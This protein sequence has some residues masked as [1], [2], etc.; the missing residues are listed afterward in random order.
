MVIPMV[1]LRVSQKQYLERTR[2]VV[3]ELREK[4]QVLKK[5][6]EEILELNDGLLVTLSEI[7][8]LRDPY[9]LGHSKLVSQYATDIAR[10]LGLKE[11]Q[12][13]L[14]RKAGLLHDIGKLGIPM[15]ILTK[16]GRLTHQEY[17]T[18]KTHSVLGGDLVKNSPSLRP[19][20]SI[21]RHHHEHFN[22]EGYP[23]QIAGSQ[24]SI[25]AR[26]VAVADAIEAMTS[27]RPY[28]KGL[29]VEQVVEELN[30]HSGTQFD[31]LVVSAAVRMLNEMEG[32][33]AQL[34]EAP[35]GQ[36]LS[37]TKLRPA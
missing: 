32:S 10:L 25:E 4:N 36:A 9:V 6:S 12:M 17:E 21:I 18:V 11:K 3:T 22:G 8:D 26:I 2:A 13:D 19:L 24:I 5:N 34:S 23:D 1:L 30:R 35:R 27:D 20:V 33:E 7:I 15:E 28:R 37:V 29:R 31:P 16:P 14:V